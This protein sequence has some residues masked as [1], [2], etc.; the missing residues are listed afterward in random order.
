[1][2]RKYLVIFC[3]SILIVLFL[4]LTTNA[5]TYFDET[6][7]D[8]NWSATVQFVQDIPPG[9][10]F[11]PPGPPFTPPGP[12]QVI[13]P[14]HIPLPSTLLLLGTGLLGLGAYRRRGIKG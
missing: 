3:L 1:M 12:P 9:P 2:P 14:S 7:N 5:D 6:F 13:P 10:P 8:D 11:D 4:T